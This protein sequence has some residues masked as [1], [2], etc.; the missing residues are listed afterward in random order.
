MANVYVGQNLLIECEFRLNGVPTDP[1]IVT[2]TSRS[3]LGANVTLTYPNAN[4]IRRS[5]GLFEASIPATEAGTW[6]FRAS[7]VGVVDA[8]NEFDMTVLA[9]GVGA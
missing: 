7:G 9:S 8:V 4:L 5:A 1:S 3:P 2:V 6:V